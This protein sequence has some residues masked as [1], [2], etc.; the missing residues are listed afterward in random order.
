MKQSNVIWASFKGDDN[1][2][3]VWVGPEWENQV[4][5]VDDPCHVLRRR[6]ECSEIFQSLKRI[7]HVVGDDGDSEKPITETMFKKCGETVLSNRHAFIKKLKW[8]SS[9]VC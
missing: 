9:I 1:V 7:G 6:L 4:W 8:Q 3:S 5:V 2:R